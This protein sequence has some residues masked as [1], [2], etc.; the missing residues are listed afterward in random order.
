MHHLY[1]I[2]REMNSVQKITQEIKENIL[3]DYLSGLEVKE[4]TKKYKFKYPRTVYFH[5]QPLSPEDK[6]MHMQNKVKGLLVK[7]RS[8]KNA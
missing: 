8:K 6:L 7:E 5:L 4:I 3:K 1:D 2:M